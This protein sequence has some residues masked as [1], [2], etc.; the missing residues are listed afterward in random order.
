MLT[1]LC[2]VRGSRYGKAIEKIKF[3]FAI[4]GVINS[5]CR[6]L[7]FVDARN[8]RIFSCLLPTMIRFGICVKS[9]KVTFLNV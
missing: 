2:D 9:H 5:S 6:I 8:P 1:E 4:T 3:T 7:F